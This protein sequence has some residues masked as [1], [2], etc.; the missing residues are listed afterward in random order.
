MKVQQEWMPL[1]NRKTRQVHSIERAWSQLAKTNLAT[2]SFQTC[3]N[4]TTGG[5][6]LRRQWL[7]SASQ[8]SSKSTCEPE[9]VKQH[10][11]YFVTGKSL[12][13][14]E[15]DWQRD[16]YSASN[17][18]FKLNNELIIYILIN[19]SIN[20]HYFL[21]LLDYILNWVSICSSSCMSWSRSS[22]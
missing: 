21:Y 4:M 1:F 13:E 17:L 7:T 5:W 3:L 14:F 11:I 22:L 8:P 12:L 6:K 10:T 15:F 16:D 2:L 18:T 19:Q 20:I 9:P